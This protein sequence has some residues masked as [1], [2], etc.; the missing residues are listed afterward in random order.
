MSGIEPRVILSTRKNLNVG[1]IYRRQIMLN[2]SID[3]QGF[4]SFVNIPQER[5]KPTCMQISEMRHLANEKKKSN[6]RED[7]K[8]VS[9][10][11]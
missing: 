9:C 8:K 5:N 1:G 6:A 4:I 2:E 11:I 3:N 7:N 10:L